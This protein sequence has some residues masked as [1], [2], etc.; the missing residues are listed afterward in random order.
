MDE[1][2]AYCPAGLAVAV[3]WYELRLA[4]RGGSSSAVR[5]LCWFGLTMGAAMVLLA[6]TTVTAA[7][8]LVPGAAPGFHLVGRELEMA[9][10]AFLPQAALR[11]T[12]R[13][14]GRMA[15]RRHLG[16]T[17]AVLAV[18][19]VLFLLARPEV[20][21]GTVT[22]DASGWPWF[23][24][25]D[26]VFTLYTLF[27]LG[28]F[29]VPVVLHARG[30]PPGPLR[31]GLRL[32]CA[33]AVV[34]L[35]WG[36]WGLAAV[37]SMV[38][39]HR[40]GAGL[41]PVAVALGTCCLVLAALGV[42]AARWGPALTAP[43]GWLRPYRELRALEP[44]WSALHTVVPGTALGVSRRWTGRVD[45]R[46]AEFALYRRVV[47]IRDGYL[48]LRPYLD[49]RI[50]LWVEGALIR[51]PVPPAGV[52]ATVE[53]ATIAAA[54]E[55]ARAGRTYGHGGAGASGATAGLASP[56]AE[57]TVDAEAAWLI[58]V[59]EAF[60]FSGAVEYTRRRAR[61]ELARP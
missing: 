3:G 59:A 46:A 14:P 38:R 23:A 55:S 2:L 21:G 17:A 25:F 5:M 35:A 56:P 43:A 54:L 60:T 22:T 37:V 15:G 27:C 13:P 58:R 31:T 10:T 42:T 30:L 41:D 49:P 1:V 33:G 57:D 29:T 4:R 26:S 34:G 53:A 24:A 12:P 51:F 45:P 39:S 20:A 7:Q 50:E 9:A 18:C 36:L 6:P 52:A 32:I 48:A 47:E 40:Q 28:L 11:L 61:D 44:L 19:P 8:H 16:A